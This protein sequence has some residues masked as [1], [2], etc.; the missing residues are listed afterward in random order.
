MLTRASHAEP[1]PLLRTAP[2][3]PYR[4]LRVE[5]GE[6]PWSRPALIAIATLAGALMLVDVTRS[7]YGNT[8]YATGALAASHSW[9][10]LLTNAADLSGY[11]SLDKGP[12]PDWLMGAVRSRAR[13]RQ[14]ERDG[15]QRAVRGG[16]VLVLHDAVRRAL[17]HQIAILAAALIMALTPVAVLVGRYNTPDALLLL[18][19]SARPG[20]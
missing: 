2:Q 9:T 15:P 4:L 16:T 18:R 10:R 17:G 20:A 11:V 6:P 1:S 8:Y 12:L 5:G 7:G 13:L 19:S 14:L 3:A